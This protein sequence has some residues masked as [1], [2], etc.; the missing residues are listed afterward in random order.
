MPL[1]GLVEGWTERIIETLTSDGT[2]FDLT[3]TRVDLV[4]WDNRN[5]PVVFSGSEGISDA[6]TGKVYFDPSP[7]DL[8]E[9]LSPY[10]IRW[11]VTDIASG[12]SA[13]FPDGLSDP[14]QWIVRKP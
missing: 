4:M 7:T 12:R 6:A 10:Q 14:G 9:A 11:K 3:G 8:L 1:E 13:F 2:P 5:R